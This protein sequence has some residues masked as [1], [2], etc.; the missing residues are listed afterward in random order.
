MII[1]QFEA[2]FPWPYR[3]TGFIAGLGSRRRGWHDK[4]NKKKQTA[5]G[6][7][8]PVSADQDH[9][10]GLG[11]SLGRDPDDDFVSFHPEHDIE[12]NLDVK[13][14]NEDINNINQVIQQR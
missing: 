10:G 14:D 4:K 13:I 1:A 2:T 9:A 5:N 11:S 12:V 3:Y 7:A 8:K 6:A